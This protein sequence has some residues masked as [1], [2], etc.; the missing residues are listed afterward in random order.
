[1]K[2]DRTFHLCVCFFF[3]FLVLGWWIQVL[4]FHF[5]WLTT[6]IYHLWC[7]PVG[8][9]LH[10]R[11]PIHCLL[12]SYAKASGHSTSSAWNRSGRRARL[13]TSFRREPFVWAH[14]LNTAFGAS[15]SEYYSMVIFRNG[16]STIIDDPLYFFFSFLKISVVYHYYLVMWFITNR[17]SVPDISVWIIITFHVSAVVFCMMVVFVWRTCNRRK[18]WM[19][20]TSI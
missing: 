20:E 18:D 7:F 14:C 10:C 16:W 9:W 1:M 4:L 5:H 8:R 2:H 19:S 12:A 13:S 3:S 15:C 11:H 6:A 17:P